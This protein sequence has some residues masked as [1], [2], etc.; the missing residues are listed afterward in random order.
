VLVDPRCRSRQAQ[1]GRAW[2]CQ[3]RGVT[4]AVPQ[5]MTEV[6]LGDGEPS[7]C[8]KV[9]SWLLRLTRWKVGC[10]RCLHVM[11]HTSNAVLVG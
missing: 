4:V 8:V 9:A 10:L 7:A 11:C 2:G 6:E 5:T 1:R 3:G